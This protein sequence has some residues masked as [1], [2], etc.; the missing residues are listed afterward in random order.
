MPRNTKH[1]PWFAEQST[2]QL[3]LRHPAGFLEDLDKYLKFMPHA[4]R[5]YKSRTGLILFL[6][7]A[8]LAKHDAAVTTVEKRFTT[9]QR[10]DKSFTNSKL[11]LT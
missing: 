6:V 3:N 1:R 11:L 2:M 5:K 8:H 9:D 10:K 4:K 7:S